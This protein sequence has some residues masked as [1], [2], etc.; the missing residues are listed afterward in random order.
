MCC[1]RPPNSN[2]IND[3]R[4]LAD[5]V[6]P[7]YEKILIAGDFN[8][9]NITWQDSHYTSLSTLGQ[10]FCDILDDYFMSQLCLQPTRDSNTLDLVISNQ[11]ELVSVI[12]IC[13]SS[14]FGMFSDHKIIRF[15]FSTTS[16]PIMSNRRLVYDC[17][18]ANFDDLRKRLTDM[19][20][21][22]RLTTNETDSSV[23]DDWS[24]W[25]NAVMT[26]VHECIP[27]KLVDPRRSPPWITPNILHQIRKKFTAR[28]RYLRKG[29]EY[30]RVKFSKLRSEVKKALQRSRE[31]FFSSLGNT[32]YVN[33]KRF[34]TIFQLKSSSGSIPGSVSSSDSNHSES[35]IHANTP[36][37][38]AT[39]FNKYC[40][41]IPSTIASQIN[42]LR[43]KLVHRLPYQAFPQLT[44]R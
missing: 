36:N 10:D 34:W 3:L 25:K 30:L 11:H 32:L 19:D 6:F 26:A 14:E 33:P 20:I 21:C 23:D 1:Y 5:N 29:T 38:V 41:F 4:S 18:Q 39:L 2:E 24:L 12:D 43:L 27:S 16:N 22:S 37:D 44:S 28:K 13:D 40:T 17:K 8:F 35:R 31:S 15:K 7:S 9:P 42:R